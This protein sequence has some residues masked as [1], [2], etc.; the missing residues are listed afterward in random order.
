MSENSKSNR[1][2]LFNHENWQDYMPWFLILIALILM[3]VMLTHEGRIWWCKWD[4]PFYLATLDAWSRH[5]S[6]HFFD[7][8][9]LTHFLHGFLFLWALD[10]IIHKILGKRISFAWLLFIAVFTET[11]WEVFENSQYIIERYREQTAS[12]DYFGDSIANSFGD[13]IACIIGFITAYL[14]RFWR[15]LAVFII[16]EIILILTIR[17]SL[18][19]NII[20]LIYPI[21]AIK[22]WQTG[23][24][25]TA[26]FI[27]ILIGK[28]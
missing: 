25:E 1:E 10:I 6:Q 22:I 9:S 15:S 13:V 8:Y 7:P 11:V 4:T 14:L 24:Q 28:I 18:L 20:M 16:I 2:K 21:E 12:L 27:Q 19:I 3:G 17:D 5:T 26:K 23:G